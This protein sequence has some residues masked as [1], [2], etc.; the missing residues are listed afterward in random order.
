MGQAAVPTDVSYKAAKI[1]L[2]AGSK[3]VNFPPLTAESGGGGRLD[4][5]N[6]VAG[7]PGQAQHLLHGAVRLLGGGGRLGC[8]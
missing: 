4:L 2:C 8:C 3:D 1:Q 6:E 7:V 5:V